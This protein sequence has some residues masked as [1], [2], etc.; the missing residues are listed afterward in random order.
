MHDLHYVVLNAVFTQE[1]RSWFAVFSL[2]II[3]NELTYLKSDLHTQDDLSVPVYK[4]NNNKLTHTTL[5]H[6]V[7]S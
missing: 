7:R 1:L 2:T 3:V 4:N 5:K 6:I